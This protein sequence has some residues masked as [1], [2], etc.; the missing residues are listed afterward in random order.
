MLE[1]LKRYI[2]NPVF[3]FIL[4][5]A[6][7]L[8]CS[9]M[10]IPKETYSNYITFS[11]A[12]WHTIS[13]LPLYIYY[14]EEQRDL[15]LYG[16]SFTTLISPFALL[17]RQVGMVLWCLANCGF[18][19]WAIKKLD[20][21]KWQFAVV[22][23]ISVNDVFTSVLSQQYSIG[24][25]AMIIFSYVLI[26]KE[27]DFWAAL[28]IVLGTMTKLYGIVGLAFFLF[29]KHKMKLT[30]GLVFWAVIVFLLPMLYAS[31]EYVVHSYKEWFD[32]LVYKNGLNQ[33]SVNQN[34]S[35]LGMLHRI[36][37]AS[38]SDLWIIVPGMILFALP[39]LR[40][41]QY[42]YES[43]RFLFLSSALLF[44]VLFSTGTETYGYLTAMVAVGVWYVKTPTK[45]AT[46]ILN[47]SLL[48]FCILLTSLSTT[49]LFPRFIRAEYVKPYALKAL[50]CTLIWLKIVWE[51]LTQDFAR[52]SD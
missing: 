17:P 35:L 36:T 47:L 50:P 31:P 20:L 32:V 19:Y 51:Q 52:P 14:P 30:G 1:R 26:E 25:T 37:G 43:F 9:L 29:S 6:V 22:I 40:I 10:L 49:D 41:R 7:A 16:I 48:I 34:I 44:M 21:K 33:F 23:L 13:S 8:V 42:Q 4:W 2:Q 3:L 27:K 18:L 24:I 12:F 38:F 15:F 5:M 28:M 39:Y 11:Q 45:A 46:P